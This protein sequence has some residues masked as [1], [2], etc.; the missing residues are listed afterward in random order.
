MVHSSSGSGTC[1]GKRG[2]PKAGTGSAVRGSEGLER[3][4][5]GLALLALTC[6][7]LLGFASCVA[8]RP[9]SSTGLSTAQAVTQ[10]SGQAGIGTAPLV[11]VT[12]AVSA[13]AAVTATGAGVTTTTTLMS[14]SRPGIPAS[15]SAVSA[16]SGAVAPS[17]NP[18]GSPSGP[19]SD[20]K[21]FVPP[22]T[23]TT[24][25]GP[26]VLL[27]QAPVTQ[28]AKMEFYSWDQI[29][30]QTFQPLPQQ[31]PVV[32]SPSSQAAL[33][34]APLPQVQSSQAPLQA[35]SAPQTPATPTFQWQPPVQQPPS[36]LTL[37][38]Q[39]L[40]QQI[41]AA[42]VPA[43]PA[44]TTIQVPLA[45]TRP[46]P[47]TVVQFTPGAATAVPMAAETPS[48]T[49]EPEGTNR[50]RLTHPA[51]PSSVPLSVP[52]K[53]AVLAARSIP[54]RQP[55]PGVANGPFFVSNGISY[56]A[57]TEGKAI[58]IFQNGVWKK[59]FLTGVNIGAGKPGHFPGELAIT[60]EEYLRWFRQISDM[61][62][63]VI[64]VY[65]TLMPAFYDAFL[66]YNRSAPKP[67][68]LM[69]GVWLAEE[70]IHIKRTAYADNDF[71]VK[72]FIQDARD[73]VDILHG[74]KTLPPKAGFASG[75][76]KSDVS[77]W[78]IGWIMGIEWDPY[79]IADTDAEYPDRA[80]YTGAFLRTRNA[81]PF[82]A[83]LC[84]VSDATI[85]WE[86]ERYK[87]MRPIAVNN[88]PTADPL[89][90]PN[91][92]YEMEDICTLD[93]RNIEAT[94]AFHSGWFA[95]FH[96]YPYYPD[97]INFDYRYAKFYDSDG[98]V[99]TYR[100]YLRE[101]MSL[102]DIPV[103]VAEFGIPASRGMAHL[104]P[105][106]GYNQ[107]AHNETEQGLMAAHL[108]QDIYQEGYCGGIVFIW[109]DE[110]FK[111]TWNN[112]DLDTPDAR[113]F[114]RNVQ[115]NE[116]MFGLMSFEPGKSGPVVVI[117][118]STTEWKGDAP[119]AAGTGIRVHAREDASYL[120]L[121][122]EISGFRFG[123]DRLVFALDT[124]PDQG[125]S[126]QKGE[127]LE[128]ARPA[129]FLVSIHRKDNSRLL[130]DGYYDPY[131]YLYGV[132]KPYIPTDPAS[133]SKD[134]GIFHPVMFALSRAVKLPQSG[135]TIPFSGY[136]TGLLTYGTS[137]ASSVDFNSMADFAARGE[138]VE[139][140]IP[141]Q[142][143]NVMNPARMKVMDDLHVKK[144]IV[145]RESGTWYIGAGVVKEGS[146]AASTV[147]IGMR[148]FS[149][150]GWDLPEYTERLK[151][152]YYILK[153]TFRVLKEDT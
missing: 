146:S 101:L 47:A 37:P 34:Q 98:R 143:L 54:A 28:G 103:L 32:L 74:N 144:G 56:M 67:L 133:K 93:V 61:N 100:A 7:I 84:Q 53:P 15:P 40:T 26:Y 87:Q 51:P 5:F 39:V 59:S 13:P 118:G 136:E 45:D 75:T 130:V 71:L 16:T 153:D 78:T 115:T 152:S 127:R 55:S 151:E 25:L 117:D 92:P 126:R 82:E 33:Q 148:P 88:W 108:L 102:Y 111:R 77:R 36:P 123:R 63:D 50:W 141:W 104:A 41:P 18:D 90:H 81:S 124:L 66:E 105:Y 131:Q 83:F 116:Q 106:S 129:E 79:F 29:S 138:A 76:Y 73:L 121:M 57:R 96:I 97:F 80:S 107:G 147:R 122:A 91:E 49:P 109:Q 119:I 89:R 142:L 10:G 52:A 12:P 132:L 2:I 60:K 120:Y 68:Y 48:P 14:P 35:V 149:L 44:R 113:P 30:A 4:T 72:A 17:S 128:F 21:L 69:Q 140:R 27:P 43:E 23:T 134:S 46:S 86:V 6:G 110:W 62:T 114:W 65:T 20:V 70:L 1:T 94:P 99:N 22:P 85:A 145:E 112:M 38:S 95:S 42:Q 24:T 3:G 58:S 64:R 11:P 8:P 150:A 9:L 139:I 19:F 135:I 31:A 125:N 137:D